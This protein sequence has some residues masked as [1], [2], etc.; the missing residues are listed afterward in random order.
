MKTK[1]F[2]FLALISFKVAL[3]QDANCVLKEKEL[4]AVLDSKDYN[5]ATELV[6]VLKIKCPSS[7]ES[8]YKTGI[9]VL[10]YNVDAANADKK[11]SAVNELVK[12]YDLY[13]KNFPNNK[14]G[15]ELNKAVLIFNTD[16]SKSSEIF[17]LL[18]KAF[19]KDKFSFTDPNILYQYFNLFVE[20]FKSKEVTFDA[21]IEKYGQVNDVV[22]KNELEFPDRKVEYTNAKMALKSLAYYNFNAVN[23]TDYIEKNFDNQKENI[24]WLYSAA[25]LLSEKST[26][27]PI[28][29]KVAEQLYTL[30]KSSKSAYYLANV[31]MKNRDMNAALSLFEESATLNIEK[32]E[33]AAIY[34][35]IAKIVA[36]TN[37]PKAKQNIDLAI[38]ND[39]NN[40]KFYIFLATLYTN[41]ISECST[42]NAQRFAIYKLAEQEVKKAALKEPRLQAAANQMIADYKKNNT[43]TKEDLEQIK[44]MGNKVKINCWINETVQF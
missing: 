1:F 37:K 39:E 31:K 11:Q 20:K 21:L 40:G 33:K 13:D 25:N 32:V 36:T 43:P 24:S 38:A 10:Q 6:N 30:D 35:N 4:L 16:S 23:L 19:S 9:K 15:N 17:N 18:D 41:S 8:F 27:P 28:F 2:L 22:T 26:N 44:K 14:N 7:S 5:K 12:F 29:G 34:Y 42:T 3:S